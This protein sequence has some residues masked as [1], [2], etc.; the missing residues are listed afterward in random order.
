MGITYIDSVTTS[1]SLISL[2]PA[3][4]VVD[5]PTA[6]LEDVTNAEN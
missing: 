2:G 4:M 6:T 1:L 3:S 5:Y